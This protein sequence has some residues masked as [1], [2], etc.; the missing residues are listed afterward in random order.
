MCH[1]SKTLLEALS[2]S[3][4]DKHVTRHWKLLAEA[5]IDG[6]E[7]AIA[8][9]ESA[10]ERETIVAPY[11]DQIAWRRSRARYDHCHCACVCRVRPLLEETVDQ[12]CVGLM[13]FI[14]TVFFH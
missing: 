5:S 8:H 12:L 9:T 11:G 4:L 14:C 6:N 1:C 2:S 13:L 3:E 10:L 7:G